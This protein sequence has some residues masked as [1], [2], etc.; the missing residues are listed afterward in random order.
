MCPVRRCCN[1]SKHTS[2]TCYSGN[3][4]IQCRRDVFRLGYFFF[5]YCSLTNT[6]A[7]PFQAAVSTV[8][9][10]C[11]ESLTIPLPIH[12]LVTKILLFSRLAWLMA[13]ATCLA[14]VQPNG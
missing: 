11:D 5:F 4:R 8:P 1:I 2:V 12:M 13:V 14:P 9:Y 3:A 10:G 6:A 7:M